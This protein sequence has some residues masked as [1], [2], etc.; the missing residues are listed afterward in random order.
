[1]IRLPPEISEPD[2]STSD[3]ENQ[4]HGRRPQNMKSAYGCSP[5][6]VFGMTTVNTNE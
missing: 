4:F 6:V 1:L 3:D 5:D 2:A